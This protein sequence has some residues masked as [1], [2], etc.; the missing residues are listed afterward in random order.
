MCKLRPTSSYLLS[1]R[2]SIN[3]ALLAVSVVI[4]GCEDETVSR[5]AYFPLQIGPVAFEAQ[6]AVDPA[7][8]QRGLMGRETLDEN[9]G[10]LFLSE[11]PR[12]QSFWMRNTLIPLDIGFFTDDGVFREVYPMYPRDETRV[13]S[14]RNDILYAL[15]MNRGWFKRN[16]IRTGDRLDLELIDRARRAL[17]T[18]R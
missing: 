2:Q 18:A 3:C 4:T 16:G 6:L 5:D 14:R 7:I 15:E 1:L 11:R 9:Q 17:A 13:V 8:Q 12:Q 10:M